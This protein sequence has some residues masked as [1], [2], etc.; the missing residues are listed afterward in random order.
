MNPF[1]LKPM[2]Q[3]S[4][5]FCDWSCLNSKPYD[6]E[7][8]SPYTKLRIILMNGTEYES[9]NFL[10][11][12]SRNC[13]NNDIRRQLALARRREQQQQKRIANLKPLNENILE[14]TIGYEHLAV[15]LTA[16]LAQREK[17]GYVKQ[18][19]DFALLEDF[20]HLYRYADL[21]EMEQGVKAQKL[22]G[23]YVEI[24]PGR[25]T[26]AEHRHPYDSIRYHIDS[27]NSDMLTVLNTMIIT[28]A[29]Q[30]TMNYYMNQGAFYEQSTLG[31]QLYTEIAMIEEQHVTQYGSLMDTN[32]TWLENNLMHEYCE[33]YLYYSCFM[34]ESDKNIKAMWE[35]LFE[36]EV[37][38]LHMAA[39]MLKKYEKKEWQQIIPVGKFPELL[40]LHS[41]KDY[42]R[43]Q[44]E[45]VRL[46]AD[47][48]NYI[49]VKEM[50]KD[51]DFF[52]YQNIVNPKT[53]NVA[54]HKVID[55]YIDKKGIDYRYQIAEH[56][57]DALRD[58]H[59]DNTTVG[60]N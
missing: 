26:I 39:Q 30:Q 33:A 9:V 18:A 21:L 59:K 37:A 11:R 48:E 3:D 5:L 45:S 10:H 38:H 53:A 40:S 16:V 22:V 56:P 12:F 35:Q 50:P 58:R 44:L 19:L 27:K 15:D 55:E 24:M 20:D 17:N 25:P 46:T 52:N 29:E 34:D 42:V 43:Q 6:K 13:D 60:L 23:E 4:K 31:R 36:Q 47:R 28:A 54:S 8:V 57:V 7:E 2:N 51:S 32:C 14:H 1:E 41:C 49:N